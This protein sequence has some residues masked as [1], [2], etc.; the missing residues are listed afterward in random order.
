MKNSNIFFNVANS[1][2]YRLMIQ[3]YTKSDMTDVLYTVGR[4]KFAAINFFW[5]F[6]LRN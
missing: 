5:S 2:T 1:M 3:C 4:D 6:T